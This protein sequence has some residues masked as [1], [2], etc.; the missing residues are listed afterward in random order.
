MARHQRIALV[1]GWG[2]VKCA[3]ALGLLRVL[4]RE[5]IEIDM[6]VASGGGSIFGSLFALGYEVEEI[7]DLNQRLWTREVTEKTNQKALL[8][9]FLPAIFQVEQYFNLRDDTLV[10]QRLRDAFGNTTFSETK[11]PLFISATE[12]QTGRQVIL[13][14]G[15]IY[16]AV[17]ATIALPLIFPPLKYGELLLA[18]GY[19]SDPL[20]VGVAV[21]EGANIILALGF[22]SISTEPRKSFSEFL[23]HLS[24]ILSNNLLNASTA[25]YNLA[26]HAEVFSIIPQFEE[27]IHMFD[28]KKVPAIIRAG[29]LEGEKLVPQLRKLLEPRI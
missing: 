10:N 27:E 14:E 7:V 24:T 13:S 26:H 21:Q 20:P 28:T 2:S 25:F 9:M 29:E 23:V 12:Y 15:Q 18:D 3:A 1:I 4:K 22:N 17:R 6:V 11:I 5:G 19:L 8:Q 16:D